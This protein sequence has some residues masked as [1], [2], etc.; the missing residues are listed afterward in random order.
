MD[1]KDAISITRFDTDKLGFG[2]VNVIVRIL[3]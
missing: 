2:D 1:T 3:L